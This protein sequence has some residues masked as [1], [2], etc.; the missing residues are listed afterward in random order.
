MIG[1]ARINYSNCTPLLTFGFTG[2][3]TEI[4]TKVSVY[5][6]KSWGKENATAHWSREYNPAVSNITYGSIEL[7]SEELDGA[8]LNKD[9]IIVEVEY[10]ASASDDAKVMHYA[11][12]TYNRKIEINKTLSYC[13]ELCDCCKFPEGLL[14]SLLQVVALQYAIETGDIDKAVTYWNK[15]YNGEWGCEGSD[16]KIGGCG[17]A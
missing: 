2:D 1:E 4:I 14:N 15:W 5:S 6:Q 9:L 7:T 12:A 11:V 3:S 13:K 8:C 10:K 17:C 16:K